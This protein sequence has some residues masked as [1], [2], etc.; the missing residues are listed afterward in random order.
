[1]VK[2]A[3][4][5]LDDK[6]ASDIVAF[7]VRKISEVTDFHVVATGLS[8]PHLKALASEVQHAL[9]EKGVPSHRRAGDPESGW[10]VLDYV[11]V[12]IHVFMPD[13]RQYYALEDLWGKAKPQGRSR[14]KT[15]P[16]R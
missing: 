1:M 4:Q 13:V 2:I 5:A 12:V 8:T 10:V 16:G 9:K 15:S 11:D 6:K 3:Q 7:D 14:K